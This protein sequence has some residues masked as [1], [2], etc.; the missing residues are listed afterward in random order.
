MGEGNNMNI[1]D[2]LVNSG[3]LISGG[4]FGGNIGGVD[5][6][7]GNKISPDEILLLSIISYRENEG[8]KLVNWVFNNICENKKQR[9]KLKH[10]GY[11]SV[12]ARS[13]R[14]VLWKHIL[15]KRLQIGGVKEYKNALNNVCRALIASNDHYPRRFKFESEFSGISFTQYRDNF[16]M[17]FYRSSMIFISSNSLKTCKDEFQRV[18]GISLRD[19][20]YHVFIIVNRYQRFDNIDY[21]KPYYLPKWMLGSD[22]PIFQGL[23]YEKIKIVLDLISKRQSSFYKEMLNDKNVYKNFNVF[24][25][26]PFLRV[27]DKMIIPLDGKFAED[28]LFNNLYYKVES[29][30]S[31][32]E[33]ITEFGIAFESYVSNLVEKACSYRNEYNFIPEFTYQKGTKKSPDAMIYHHE[34]NTML[35]IECKSSRVLN[36]MLDKDDGN[37]SF[38]RNVEKLRIKPWKQMHASISNIIKAEYDPAF[39]EKTMYVFLCVTMNN[40]PFYP[41]EMKIEQQGRR[42]DKYFFTMSIEEF[43]IFMEVLSSE[44]KFTFYEILLG[45]RTHQNSMSMKTYL[46]RIRENEKLF[47]EKYSAYISSSLKAVWEA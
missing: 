8:R 28:L 11:V 19:Y 23:D 44:S 1:L 31:R 21:F 12:T 33:F 34:N 41:V 29:L 45:Y 25:N 37:V 38:D 14:L 4:V 35:V 36:A 13:E 40:I 22:D 43:E 30:P 47:N 39:S 17:Q 32:E 18:N 20:I 26:N 46:N 24:K 16:F 10:G 15:S 6:L 5:D 27:N 2:D 7:I 3:Y 42:I 9:H